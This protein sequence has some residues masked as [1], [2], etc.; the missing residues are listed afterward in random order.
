MNPATR[1]LHL[2][3]IRQL[4]GILTAWEKWLHIEYEA[5]L[6]DGTVKDAIAEIGAGKKPALVDKSK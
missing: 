6:P 2:S 4:K 1:E 3:L 5:G